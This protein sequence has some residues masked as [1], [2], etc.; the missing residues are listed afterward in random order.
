MN[1]KK[2]INGAVQ[3]NVKCN[4]ENFEKDRQNVARVKTTF[5]QRRIRR[6]PLKYTLIPN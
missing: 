4:G 1:T 2:K 6:L 3:Y 5:Q